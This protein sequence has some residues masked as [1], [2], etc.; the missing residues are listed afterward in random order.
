M[1]GTSGYVHDFAVRPTDQPLDFR[2]VH[3]WVQV[4]SRLDFSK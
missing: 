3:G 4:L 1:T 2:Y